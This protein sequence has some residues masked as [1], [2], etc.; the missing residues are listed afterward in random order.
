MIKNIPHILVVEDEDSIRDMI[1][2]SLHAAN[3]KVIAAKNVT[4]ARQEIDRQ[5][6]DLILLDWMLPGI[7]GIDFAKELKKN[8]QTKTIRIILLTAREEEEN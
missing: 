7:S 3:F 4:E 8:T 2:L 5:F 6:P 1:M